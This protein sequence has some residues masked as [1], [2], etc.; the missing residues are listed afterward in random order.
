MSLPNWKSQIK[1]IFLTILYQCGVGP[2]GEVL[3]LHTNFI[4]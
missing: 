1:G 3:L 2:S 4:E